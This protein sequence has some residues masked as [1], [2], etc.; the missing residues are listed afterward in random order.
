MCDSLKL[1][2]INATLLLI[3]S[4]PSAFMLEEASHNSLCS[5]FVRKSAPG[6]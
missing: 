6:F 4:E 3:H 2:T 1:L 5:T